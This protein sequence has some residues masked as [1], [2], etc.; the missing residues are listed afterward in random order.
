VPFQSSHPEAATLTLPTACCPQPRMTMARTIKFYKLPEEPLTPGLRPME[1]KDVPQV[2]SLLN[3]YLE[4]YK[5]APTFSEEEVAHWCDPPAWGRCGK[6]VQRC[7]AA[8][9][10]ACI[11]RVLLFPVV[12]S[13]TRVDRQCLFGSCQCC[14]GG[15]SAL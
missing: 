9:K 8:S 15:A 4:R 7:V 12:C 13:L 5:L 6:R 2:R 3:T 1:P 11:G 14:S 10:A